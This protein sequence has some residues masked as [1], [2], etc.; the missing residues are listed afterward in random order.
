MYLHISLRGMTAMGVLLAV[1][2]HATGQDARRGL[3]GASDP[4]AFV[5]GGPVAAVLAAPPDPVAKTPGD[6]T[7]SAALGVPPANDVCLNAQ[8]VFGFGQ[9]PFDTSN[10]TPDGLITAACTFFGTAEFDADLWYCFTAPQTGQVIVET[11]GLTAVDTRLAVYDACGPCPPDESRVIVCSDDNCN[12]QTRIE[13]P[14]AAGQSY[15]IRVGV[16]PGAAPGPGTLSI[17]AGVEAIPCPSSFSCQLADALG[18][19][20][21]LAATSDR[22]PSANFRVAE[23]I[24]A[25]Q[26]GFITAVCWWGIYFDFAIGAACG[27]GPDNFEI[28]YYNDDAGGEVPGTLRDGPFTVFADRFAT[29]RVLPVAGIPEHQYEAF[30][31]P[32]F[33]APSECLWIEIT[34]NVGGNCFWLWQTAP[35][36][37]ARGAQSVG[38][39]YDATAYD[40]AVCLDIFFASNGCQQKLRPPNDACRDAEFVT[41]LPFFTA[42]STRFATGDVPPA[43]TCG[44]PVSAPGVWYSFLG[45][46]TTVTI[47]TC[48]VET[49][50]DT[51]LNVYCG[52]C[53]SLICVAGN[54]DEPSCVGDPQASRVT[55][56]TQDCVLYHVLVQG[57]GGE[58]GAFSLEISNNGVPCAPTPPT[59]PPC[60]LTCPAGSI[61]E[62]EPCGANFNGGCDSVPPR[63][64]AINCGQTVCG[65]A[66]ANGG[67]RDTDWYTFNVPGPGTFGVSWTV[68]AEFPAVVAL[69]RVTSCSPPNFET[70]SMFEA[71]PCEPTAAAAVLGPGTYVALVAP[72]RIGVPLLDGYPCGFKDR[73]FGTLTCLPSPTACE[74]L[75][76]PWFC[77]DPNSLIGNLSGLS[78][79]DVLQIPGPS[80]AIPAQNLGLLFRGDELDALSF[81]NPGIGP[82][83][84]FLLRFGVNRSTAGGVPPDPQFAGLGL[85]YNVQH[86]ATR[87]Q[88]AADEYVS[89]TLFNR[90]GPLLPFGGG[91]AEN[92]T[93][94]RNQS[95]AG[96]VDFYLEPE[97]APDDS[98]AGDESD[99]KGEA[100]VPPAMLGPPS[101][102]FYSLRRG[103]ASLDT[104]PGTG[105]AADIYVDNNTNAPGS[106]VLYVAPAQIGLLP[107][108]DLD[109]L[110]VLDNGD[111]I[112]TPGQDQV[113]FSLAAG[114]PSLGNGAPRSP[115]D[116]FRSNGGGVFNVYA[117]AQNLGLAPTDELDALEFSLCGNV[118]DCALRWGIGF[119][120]CGGCPGGTGDANCD[121]TV[122]FFDIDPFL[123]A[124]F[125][126]PGYLEVYCGGSLCAADAS[127][128]GSVDF[129]D[130][131]A[132]LACLF[133][134][135]P[136]CP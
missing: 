97:I 118:L 29:G 33:I 92:N 83:Q 34:N 15:L 125:N 30:H 78:A 41:A 91:T 107:N 58:V 108:D 53:N 21:V 95:D 67:V 98:N 54:D 85:P 56:C 135:C 45:D 115:A 38:G 88:A 1:A 9:I 10:A 93:K 114:S 71:E 80:I 62:A 23:S 112:F 63:F 66:F 103:S 122:D 43:T 22:N 96:G 24:R 17:S 36:G 124:L 99:V 16:F 27:P 90:F 126:S 101:F 49:D 120:N 82:G 28:T 130:I 14:A 74:P 134:T 104:L 11:C 61:P 46:G 72:G 121:G 94:T 110:I 32:V 129:F 116:L 8:V 13:F 102:I 109:A 70:L 127:C 35:A 12:L 64:Q 25:R 105:S 113:I 132:F 50:Y 39:V 20:G 123:L 59:C 119:V 77:I 2:A 76:A 52:P 7:G 106:E 131:D 89:L 48:G 100:K 40:L 111:R 26:P 19:G 84:T 31:P 81:D 117:T 68:Q 60:A 55:I 5:P 47:T 3:P 86:Q 6:P 87:R 136:P 4:H 44:T 57:F 75:D 37:D 42:G 79:A 18:H 128:D 51:Q 133:S 73:Y 65:T 69:L